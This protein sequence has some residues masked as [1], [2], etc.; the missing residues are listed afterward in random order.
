M[1]VLGCVLGA[2]VQNGVVDVAIGGPVQ[3]N[4]IINLSLN[5]LIDM[6]SRFGRDGSGCKVG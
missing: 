4:T 1:L 6:Q 5:T 3:P 2:M